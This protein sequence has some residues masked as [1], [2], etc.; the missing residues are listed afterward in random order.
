ME[1]N[2]SRKFFKLACGIISPE[3]RQKERTIRRPQPNAQQPLSN[4]ELCNMP[5]H[6][7]ICSNWCRIMLDYKFGFQDLSNT[8]EQCLPI[9]TDRQHV[10]GTKQSAR[11]CAP[12]WLRKLSDGWLRKL[13]DGNIVVDLWLLR[14]FTHRQHFCMDWSTHH[15]HQE[16]G[17]HR[18]SHPKPIN[19]HPAWANAVAQSPMIRAPDTP[20]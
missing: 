7:H 10:R 8:L 18:L 16:H 4:S 15:Q 9:C 14:G 20:E 12:T 3:A 17:A 1:H 11:A 5:R 13:D 2:C 19:E 6:S